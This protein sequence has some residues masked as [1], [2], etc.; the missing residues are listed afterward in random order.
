MPKKQNT[1]DSTSKKEEEKVESQVDKTE[2]TEDETTEDDELDD[3][4]GG[5]DED[6]Q[7]NASFYKAEAERLAVEKKQAED[8]LEAAESARERQNEIKDRALQA[9]KERRRKAEAAPK[10]GDFDPETIKREAVEEFERRQS[11]REVKQLIK[12]LTN[13]PSAQEVITH[14]AETM[15]SKIENVDDRVDAAIAYANRKRAR[16]LLVENTKQNQE[17]DD[18]IGSMSGGNARSRTSS[19]PN[20]A[21]NRIASRLVS[22][23]R[24]KFLK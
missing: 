16:A 13:D 21:V 15:F 23:D 7:E 20:N 22:K 6:K 19:V 2:T 24:I 5:E 17:D 1:D 8:A 3:T 14:Y 9:E 4:E 10:Q 11:A 12:T 18:G